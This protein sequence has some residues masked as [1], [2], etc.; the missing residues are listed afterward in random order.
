M[1]VLRACLNDHKDDAD[2][3]LTGKFFQTFKA[4]KPAVF[5]PWLVRTGHSK[6][7]FDTANLVLLGLERVWR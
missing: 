1:N 7:L 6:K 2:F 5:F 4:A 3:T